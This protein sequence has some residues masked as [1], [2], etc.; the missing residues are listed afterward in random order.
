MK[1][2]ICKKEGNL[3]SLIL[4]GKYISKRCTNCIIEIGAELERGVS[5]TQAEYSRERQ[6]EDYRKDMLQPF[7]GDKPNRDFIIAYPE[8]SKEYFT[9]KE[10]RDN[11]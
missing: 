2:P 4:N 7:I 9:K 11:E 6:R 3:K 10:L 1:C 8:E 5:S